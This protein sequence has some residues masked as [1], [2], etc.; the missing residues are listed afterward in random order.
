MPIERIDT[1]VIGGGQAGL[2]MSYRLKQRGIPHLVLERARIAER[3]RSERWDGLKFQFPNWSVQLPDFAFPHSD[4]DAFATSGEIVE[5]ID[6]FAEFIAPP[7]RCGVEVTHLKGGDAGFIAESTDGTIE[8]NN[9]VVATGPYQQPLMPDLLRDHPV[10]QVH[11]SSYRNPGQ[12]PPGAVLVVGAGASG[13]QIADELHRAG[14]R[15]F[16]S[17]GQH[18]RMPRR[19]RGQDLTWWFGALRLFDMTAEQRGPIRVNPSI[20]GAYGGYTIDFRRFT[21]DGITLLG[22]VQ[23][24]RDGVLDIAPGLAENL[25]NGDLY[26]SGFLDMLDA[27]VEQHGLDL[28]ADPAARTVLA[29]PPCVTEPIRRLDLG[30][31]EIQAVVWATGYGVDFSWIDLPV[32]DGSGEPVHRGGVS[33][34]PGLYFLGLPYLSKLYSAFLSGVGDDAAVLADHIAARR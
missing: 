13:A 3:W 11:A 1:L 22:R 33:E 32:R 7:I 24:A 20:T 18:T 30:K 15:V 34:V 16:L 6:A 26:Y 8:A 12:L 23:A 10:F 14:R 21:A 19:Y 25:A 31:E 9:V 29:D 28:P 17:V 2:V 5:F 27:H 4:P